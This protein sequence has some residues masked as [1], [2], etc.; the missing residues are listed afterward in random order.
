MKNGVTSVL[1]YK[2][3]QFLIKI[4]VDTFSKYFIISKKIKFIIDLL[5]M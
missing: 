2:I 3:F 4:L 1:I 5:F